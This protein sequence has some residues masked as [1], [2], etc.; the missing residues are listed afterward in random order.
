MREQAYGRILLTTSSSGLYGNF[1]Q[2]N[3]G[4]AKAGMIGLMNCLHLEGAKYDI[5]VNCLS[6][7]AAT[8]MTSGLLAPEDEALLAPETV[9]PA[10]LFLTS[11]D[12][13]SR[14]IMGAGAGVYSVVRVVETDGVW[15]P[16]GDRTVAGI[17]RR[18]AEI[19]DAS[20]ARPLE[21]AFAQTNK[22][23]ALARR[24]RER[25]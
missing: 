9:S 13:P 10:A 11:G 19:G 24:A 22:Y 7:T 23:S 14:I 18:F 2:S 16:P 1:G 12:A 5:R 8:A 20:T 6:P 25:P 3:Y 17:A 15:L 4:A 21:N